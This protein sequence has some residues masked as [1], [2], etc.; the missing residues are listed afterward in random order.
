MGEEM[1]R[2]L[3]LLPGPFELQSSQ[4]GRESIDNHLSF[5]RSAE[6]S[7]PGA[8]G[9]I[10]I[11]LANA[12]GWVRCA[13]YISSVAEFAVFLTVNERRKSE[14]VTERRQVI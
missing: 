1:P 9:D 7:L 2:Q 13:S 12:L 3:R 4:F 6:T 14:Q 11:V 5:P 10:A 8:R